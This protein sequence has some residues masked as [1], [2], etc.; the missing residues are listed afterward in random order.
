MIRGGEP[1]YYNSP[2]SS[3]YHKGEILYGLQ[4]ARRYIPLKDCVIIAEGYFDLLTLHQYGLKHSVATLGTA[5]TTQHI[6]TLKR[7]TRNLIT[8]FDADPAGI[9][10]SLR[11]LPLFLEEEVSGKTVLLPKGEDPDSFLRKGKAEELEQG[12]AEAVPLIDFFFDRL[13]KTYDPKSIDGKVK[14]A[15]EGVALV[16]KIPGGIRKDFY[17]RTLAERLDLKESLLHEIARPSSKRGMKVE[18]EL[19]RPSVEKSLPKSEEMMVRLIIHHPEWMGIISRE[20]ILQEFESPQ[21][22]KMAE[23]LVNLYQKK[24]RLDISEA[25]GSIEEGL[26]GKLR[27]F[28]LQESGLE[29]TD[30]ERVLRDCVQKIRKKKLKRDESD[31]LKRI[32]EAEKQKGD[33]G[34]E[35]LLLQR[36]ELARRERGL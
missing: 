8:V 2:E 16:S 35:A 27:E 1:K 18:E 29:G 5:L 6:R 31:L 30:Q 20:G 34:L 21:L 10:A 3:I 22:R 36:Q 17:L 32:K 14:I 13:M 23:H 4:V 12:V 15:E 25:L 26:K 19:K 7:Y 33:K 11:S 24:G 9:Q 28:S